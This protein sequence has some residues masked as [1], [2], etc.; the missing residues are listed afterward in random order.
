MNDEPGE[1]NQHPSPESQQPEH[2]TRGFIHLVAQTT[3][4]GW[5]MVVPIIGGVLL[6]RYLDDRFDKEFTWTLS[7]L[8]LGIFVAFNNLYTM[9][10]EH[11]AAD[12]PRSPDG[13][14]Q[15]EG[16]Q[17]DENQAHDQ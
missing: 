17:T 11:S 10:V 13:T 12:P 4:L 16:G 15:K 5:N 6:G 1:R 2:D 8:L 7:L 14:H 3:S 9:Y